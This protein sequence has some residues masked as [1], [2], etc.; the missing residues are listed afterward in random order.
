MFTG[1][2]EEV[3]AVQSL[4]EESEGTALCIQARNVLDELVPGDSISVDGVCLTVTGLDGVGFRVGLSPE[5]L[6]RTTLGRL[7]EEDQVN[8]E[9]AIRAGS[10]LG[11]HYV[12]GHV[13]GVGH[14][15]GVRAD[16][17]SLVMSFEIDPPLTRYVVEKGFVAVD[18]ISL[19]VTERVASQFSVALVSFT[20]EHVAL[21]RKRVGDEVNIEVDI[22]AKYVESILNG[23][24]GETAR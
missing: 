15:V 7:K 14:V 20:Q 9:R 18:G 8:L 21:A 22:I 1:I 5:T 24:H 2:I 10:R 17:D 16:G 11:G 13:D 4:V 19:T 3:G 12:Q 6:R 23:I